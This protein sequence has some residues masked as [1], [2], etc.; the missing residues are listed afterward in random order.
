MSDASAGP[1]PRTSLRARVITVLL[2]VAILPAVVTSILSLFAPLDWILDLLTHF[3]VQHLAWFAAWTIAAII[4]RRRNPAILAAAF[5]LAT[6]IPVSHYLPKRNSSSPDEGDLRIVAF[7]ILEDNPEREA[8]TSWL[9]AQDADI[10]VLPEFS[11]RW[12]EEFKALDEA[13]PHHFKNAGVGNFG[14]VIYSRWPIASRARHSFCSRRI[15]CLEITVNVGGRPLRVFGVHPMAP[16]SGPDTALRDEHLTNLTTHLKGVSGPYVVA[17]DFNA[18][19][20]SPS[21]KTTVR[22]LQLQDSG[23]GRGLNPSYEAVNPF[24]GIQIDHI[25]HTAD[26]E[27]TA[28][29]NGPSLGSDH[30]PV[31]AD[32]RLK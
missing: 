28:F 31:V 14:F 27:T 8:A 17:G 26:L 7:N 3:R 9:L 2:Y 30:R 32:L 22:T 21:L 10:L 19:I 6:A 23:H 1:A 4:L 15:P 25:F 24:F 18:T 29:R 12:H 20:F 11:Y 16:I 13:Y 5:A